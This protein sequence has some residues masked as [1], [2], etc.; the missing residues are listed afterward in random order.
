[1][2]MGNENQ[3]LD[4]LHDHY[5]ESFTQ[6]RDREKVRDK[7][8]LWVSLLLG[9]LFLEVHFPL[10]IKEMFTEASA[11]CLKFN[12]GKVPVNI[13]ASITWAILFIMS[14]RYCQLCI[15][16]DRQYKY[17]H[18]LEDKLS[19]AIGDKKLFRREGKAYKTNYP[20]FSRWAWIFY[21]ILFPV[22]ML[23]VLIIIL[24]SEFK[25]V[26]TNFYFIFDLLIAIALS[27]SFILYRGVGHYKKW[28]KKRKSKKENNG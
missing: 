3:N 5:K 12:P 10:V 28:D 19:K 22:I 15:T 1:M 26:Q 21:T 16:V 6:I 25:Q 24:I 14:I 27:T 9:L 2:L 23:F 20:A 17:L 13:L 11:S 4:I 7:I 18:L 8:F